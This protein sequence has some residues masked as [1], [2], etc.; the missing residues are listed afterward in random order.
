METVIISLSNHC[1]DSSKRD[2]KPS[3]KDNPIEPSMTVMEEFGVEEGSLALL[4]GLVHDI[5]ST[6]QSTICSDVGWPGP[7]RSYFVASL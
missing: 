5:S 6:A 4:V 3:T 2:L 1:A 7:W